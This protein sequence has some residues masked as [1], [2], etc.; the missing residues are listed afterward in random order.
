[1]DM[2]KEGLIS[3]IIPVYNSRERLAECLESV[4]GQSYPELE[5]IIVDDCS[6]DGSLEICRRF[7]ERYPYFHVFTKEN[8]GVSSARNYGISKAAGRYLQFVDS[9]DR[10]YPDACRQLAGRMERDRSDLVIGGYYNEKEQRDIVHP[11]ALLEGKEAFMREFPDLFTGFFLHVPWNK[12]YRRELVRDGF[13]EDLNKGEDLLFNLQVF[14]EAERISI[15]DR[16]LYFY[17][18][19]SDSSLSFRFRE[20]AM[21]IE[22]RLY[23]SVLRF[24]RENGG[25]DVPEFLDRFYLEAVKN[26]FYALL[27]KSGLGFFKCRRMIRDWVGK[28][29]LR[30]LYGR[31]RIFG[32]KD[33]ILLALM[34]RKLVALL[35]FYYKWAGAR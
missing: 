3:I 23:L 21:E 26:K 14:A 4:A 35:Y 34:Q 32:K 2:Q 20:D 28:D 24:W 17:H 16:P 30:G 25:G 11:E 10:L 31:R 29:S 15:L 12:L 18:N 9:D 22:E 19:V 13:P 1:M 7:E 8:E 27:G 5:V 33:R 6:T